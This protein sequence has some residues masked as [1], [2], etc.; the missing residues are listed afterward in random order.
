M[1]WQI[2]VVLAVVVPAALYI[3]RTFVRQFFRSEDEAG[4]CSGC[5][6]NRTPASRPAPD[7]GRDGAAPPDGRRR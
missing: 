1:D 2:L 4:A 5:P 6:A 3:G 7:R